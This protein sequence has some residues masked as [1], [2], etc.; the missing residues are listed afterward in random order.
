VTSPR[1]P[2][3]SSSD[4][5]ATSLTVSDPVFP[6]AAAVRGAMDWLNVAVPGGMLGEG[7]GLRPTVRLTYCFRR[8]SERSSCLVVVAPGPAPSTTPL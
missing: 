4:T 1:P 7:V 2:R 3:A 6:A 8:W 5:T